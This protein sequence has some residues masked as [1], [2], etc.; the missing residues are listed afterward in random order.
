MLVSHVK[1]SSTFVD[2]QL[3][4]GCRVLGEH[5]IS[6]EIAV[7]AAAPDK[8]MIQR[9][10]TQVISTATRAIKAFLRMSS[11]KMTGKTTTSPNAP[12]KMR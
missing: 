3:I 12:K 5:I 4:S 7:V 10:P 1:A 6:D 11:T 9:S 8:F 2:I